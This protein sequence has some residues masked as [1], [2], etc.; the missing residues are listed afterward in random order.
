MRRV[1]SCRS[2][3][4]NRCRRSLRTNSSRGASRQGS[5]SSLLLAVRPNRY[6]RRRKS[7]RTRKR[8]CQV[9]ALRPRRGSVLE[10]PP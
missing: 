5:H 2:R 10:R 6:H 7:P 4:V 1:D 3:T 9:L 8:V